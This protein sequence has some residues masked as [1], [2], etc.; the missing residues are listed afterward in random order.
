LELTCNLAELP[1]YCCW[2]RT[3]SFSRIDI[4]WHVAHCDLE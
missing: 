1:S 2:S 3:F 4:S